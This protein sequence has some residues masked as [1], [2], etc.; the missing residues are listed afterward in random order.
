MA[1]FWFI[2]AGCLCFVTSKEIAKDYMEMKFDALVD[3]IEVLENSVQSQ[4]RMIHSQQDKL[5]AMKE[6]INTQAEELKK[7]HDSIAQLQ[8]TT[9][10]R[11]FDVIRLERRVKMFESKIP[12]Q[13][14]S[15]SV[16]APPAGLDNY[17]IDYI[18][19][20][21]STESK[22]KEWTIKSNSGI[23]NKHQ[24]SGNSEA[25]QDR[26]VNKTGKHSKEVMIIRI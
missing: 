11:R 8:D 7:Q 25:K 16:D 15:T 2:L 1:Y 17:P 24:Q 14:I 26:F 21:N 18:N 13:R 10:K 19:N 12:V 20:E 4:N 5:A 3:R 22:E 9:N 6:T 23:S